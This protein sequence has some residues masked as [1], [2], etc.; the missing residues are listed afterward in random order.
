M[1]RK[2]PLKKPLEFVGTLLLILFGIKPK[3]LSQNDTS[4][5]P[6]PVLNIAKLTG[7]PPRIGRN[8]FM[9]K[10]NHWL[11]PHEVLQK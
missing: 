8:V 5:N 2:H 6:A 1:S 7:T 9:I 3:S 11:N 10:P 4:T